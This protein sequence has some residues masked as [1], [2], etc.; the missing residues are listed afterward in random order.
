MNYDWDKIIKNYMNF[1]KDTK[2]GQQ[3]VHIILIKF[4]LSLVM[5]KSVRYSQITWCLKTFSWYKIFDSFIQYIRELSP[6]YPHDRMPVADDKQYV[7]Q[8]F[9]C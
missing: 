4:P 2:T 9:V 1:C 7:S 5:E 6:S 8:Y 3:I